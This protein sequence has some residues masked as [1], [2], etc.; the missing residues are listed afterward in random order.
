MV[1]PLQAPA[2]LSQHSASGSD[3]PRAFLT[4]CKLPLPG[5]QVDL[6]LCA[7]CLILLTPRVFAPS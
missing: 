7:P 5:L 2:D 3:E 4:M 1:T 6:R